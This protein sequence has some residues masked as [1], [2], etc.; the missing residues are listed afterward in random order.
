MPGALNHERAEYFDKICESIGGAASTLV[1][2]KWSSQTVENVCIEK[3]YFK[4]EPVFLP[5]GT[6]KY[7]HP[8]DAQLFQDYK[9]LVKKIVEFSKTLR[10]ISG[11]I[12]LRGK[13]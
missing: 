3:F 9:Y 11:D 2:D 5:P 7:L 1:L 12:E 10:N 8:L 13:S 6:T 4:I